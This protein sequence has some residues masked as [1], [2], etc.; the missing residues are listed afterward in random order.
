MVGPKVPQ[1]CKVARDGLGVPGGPGDPRG[2]RGVPGMA[3]G[4]QK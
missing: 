2:D 1:G 3:W 4:S